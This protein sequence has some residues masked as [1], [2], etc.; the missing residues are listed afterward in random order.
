LGAEIKM[1]IKN[2]HGKPLISFSR[3][4]LTVILLLLVLPWSAPGVEGERKWLNE[5]RLSSGPEVKGFSDT[6][7]NGFGETV[8][9]WMEN[10]GGVIHEIARNQSGR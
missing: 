7:V 6:E 8:T 5:M 3:L 9:V 1:N 4:T 10:E 2:F